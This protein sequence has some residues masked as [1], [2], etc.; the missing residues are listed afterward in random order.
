MQKRKIINDPV[1]GFIS[2]PNDLL[3][4]IIEHPYFQR[5]NRIKQLGLSSYVYPGAHH[6]RFLHSIGA[7]HLMEEAINHLRSRGVEISSQEEEGVLATILL[8]DI[9]HA[10]FSHVLE[11][12]FC[13]G[14]THEDISLEIMKALDIEF[15]GKLKTCIDIYQN[16]YKKKFLHQL[17]SS[18]LDMDRLDY[19]KRDSFFTGV[20]EGSIGTDRIIKML[21]VKNDNLCVESKGIYSIE[22]FLIARRIMYWQVYY[23][24][25]SVSAERLLINILY[26]AKEYIKQGNEL[27]CPTCMKYFLHNNPT[28]K[29]FLNNGVAMQQYMN[30]DDNDI[31]SSI[32]MWQFSEDIVL[33]TLSKSLV[34]RNFFKVIINENPLDL[35]LKNNLEDSYVKKFGIK[36]SDAH[37]FYSE[38]SVSTNTYTHRKNN[39]P[40]NILYEDGRIED[41]SLSSNIVDIGMLN[42]EEKKYYWC[43]YKI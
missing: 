23:H 21:N 15:G 16:T 36:K 29:D 1:L 32:K 22:N 18:Q 8:H 34:N 40:I 38:I 37:Y 35:D 19:L 3:Y 5:L 41:L 26:R 39:S 2:I 24:K 6:T 14:L 7:M 31:I 13:S 9:G 30:F 20:A 11:H 27:P 28:K 42:K 17:V 12:I 43:Y 25:T 10:P 33:S 4:A